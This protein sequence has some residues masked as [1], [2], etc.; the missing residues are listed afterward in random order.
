MAEKDNLES[1]NDSLVKE[2][3]NSNQLVQNSNE[4]NTNMKKTSRMFSSIIS[5]ISNNLKKQN[6][7][8]KTESEREEKS[9]NKKAKIDKKQK[10]QDK[11]D[12]KGFIGIAAE[13]T[14]TKAKGKITDVA[15][16][17]K[18]AINP[19]N[20]IKN[21]GLLSGSPIISLMSDTIGDTIDEIRNIRAE[22][23]SDELEESTEQ[24]NNTPTN[25]VEPV[26]EDTN[27]E[28]FDNQFNLLDKLLTTNTEGFKDLISN[29]NLLKSSEEDRYERETEDSFLVEQAQEETVNR[30]EER[31]ELLKDIMDI[32]G[33]DSGDDQEDSLGFFDSL[34]SIIGTKLGAIIGGIGASLAGVITTVVGGLGTALSGAIAL[35]LP[36]LGVAVAG[37]I[38]F[39]IGSL[40]NNKVITPLMDKIYDKLDAEQEARWK[41]E[42]DRLS[43]LA[44][45]FRTAESVREKAAAKALIKQKTAL[46]G[47]GNEIII[48]RDWA[49]DLKLEQDELQQLREEQS[50]RMEENLDLYLKFS[51]D[52]LR[53]YRARFA[54]TE[55]KNVEWTGDIDSYGIAR[56]D[57]F[58][59]FLGKMGAERKELTDQQLSE[60]W[61]IDLTD[62]IKIE[63]DTPFEIDSSNIKLEGS[64]DYIKIE[65]IS[66]DMF[67]KIE[68]NTNLNALENAQ[69]ENKKIEA[70][71]K[72]TI[73]PVKTE[74]T[75]LVSNN[76]NY[77][78]L[79]NDMSTNT[80]DTTFNILSQP[81]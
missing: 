3:E 36:A 5:Q 38:G 37:A 46:M 45:D 65:G 22:S 75:S 13:K 51:D 55:A 70:Q 49:L 74:N 53:S 23:K 48:E 39:G 77:S 66:E 79:A 42:S 59:D 30:D 27:T 72:N 17:I 56:E 11:K 67:D 64:T 40:L 32:R 2:N 44:E 78:V 19:K 50:K 9:D 31:N 52:E 57:A 4:L 62:P 60:A 20:I 69:I 10:A 29:F 54:D 8:F 7:D 1:I 35:A 25:I 71:N 47:Q 58:Q 18:K 34:K 12:K 73:E 80:D 68:L 6:E 24:V 28:F 21:V 33:D 26:D 81:Y 41:E 63:Q 15:D 43:G 61:N 76:S 16:D 14:A